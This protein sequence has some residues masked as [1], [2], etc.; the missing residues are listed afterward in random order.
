MMPGMNPRDMKRLMK[1]LNAKSI[2]AEKVIIKSKS[3]NIIIRNPDVTQMGLGGNTVFQI[4]GEV[5]E[6][7]DFEEKDVKLVMQKT[8]KDEKQVKKALEKNKGDIAQ[9]IMDLS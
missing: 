1:K 9:T 2:E 7:S 5:S 6:K 4:T 3:K 8:N